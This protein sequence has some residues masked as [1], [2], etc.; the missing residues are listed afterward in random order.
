MPLSAEAFN[1]LEFVWEQLPK[2]P[3]GEHVNFSKADI[4]ALWHYGFV[5]TLA[6]PIASWHAAFDPHRQ[7]DGAY[8]L[9]QADFLAKERYRYRGE[10]HV[11]FD[12][13]K[14]NEGLY[15]DEGLQELI[16]ESVA[17]S[18]WAPA[19]TFDQFLA[20]LKTGTRQPDGLIRIDMAAKQR[21]RQFIDQY[22]SPL[23][24]LEL[25]FDAMIAQQLA[26]AA[27][28]MPAAATPD[29]AARVEASTFTMLPDHPIAAKGK[30]LKGL[31]K[32]RDAAPVDPAKPTAP[33]KALRRSRKGVRG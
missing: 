20:G 22:P 29:Q 12:A 6:V 9:N 24:R 26:G 31:E 1:V 8:L 18:V 4:E 15:T 33:L 5:D 21:I 25:I 32:A 30:A 19:G 13:R 28:A 27:G 11:P 23:R 2:A 16:D 10:I 3:D 14:I 17:P 7:P